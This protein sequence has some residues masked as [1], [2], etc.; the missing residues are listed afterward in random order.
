MNHHES[1]PINTTNFIQNKLTIDYI[2]EIIQCKKI[3]ILSLN[4]QWSK[5][6]CLC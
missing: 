6:M 3:K 2:I 5:K 4:I 1:S